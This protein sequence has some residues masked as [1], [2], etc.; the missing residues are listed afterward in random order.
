M[1]E[2]TKHGTEERIPECTGV[3]RVAL[4]PQDHEKNRRDP[5]DIQGSY[6]GHQ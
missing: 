3:Q 1:I 6:V 4:V 5:G 2:M